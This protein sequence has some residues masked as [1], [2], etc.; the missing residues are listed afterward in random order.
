MKQA[1]G[2]QARADVDMDVN[3]AVR[4]APADTA[5]PARDPVAVVGAGMIG[6]G[7]AIVFA[8]AGH[9][10][11]LW[12]PD[13]RAVAQA[14]AFVRDKVGALHAG[15]LAP[16]APDVV[17]SRIT[18][19]PDLQA[20]VA[21]AAHVQENGP[22]NLERR[23]ALFR[24]LDALAPA[25]A[26]IASSTSGMPPSAFTA[27]LPGRARCLVAHPPNPPYLL[28]LVE[29]CPAPWTSAQAVDR[30]LELMRAAGRKPARMTREKDGFILNRLQGALLAEAFR[31][32]DEDV[33][34]VHDLDNVIKHGLGL[35]WAFMGPI[36]TVDLNAPGGIADFCARYGGLYD[37][38]QQQMTP[39]PWDPA[40]VQRVAQARRADLPLTDIEARQAWRDREL[41]ALAEH[42][43]SRARTAGA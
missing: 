37:A 25:Q 9:P 8:S 20:C 11:S 3:V 42:L 31:L 36:E 33:V 35:R 39:R 12:D 24:E 38:L 41:L 32:I 27:D 13:S 18:C 2:E 17:M 30:T 5:I 26:I 22:E 43:A 14:L 19:Q 10:V 29:V 34:S 6:R 23:I 16:D 21:G 4:A 28:P 7:W 1:G 40:L 15:G